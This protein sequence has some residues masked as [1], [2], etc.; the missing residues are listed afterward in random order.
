MQHAYSEKIKLFPKAIEVLETSSMRLLN[1]ASE[2]TLDY[3]D[4]EIPD[5]LIIIGGN[6]L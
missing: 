2:H 1:S 5:N 3:D 6:I 4:E